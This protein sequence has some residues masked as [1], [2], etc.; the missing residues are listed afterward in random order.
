[1]NRFARS[2]I[3]G[4]A[5]TILTLLI[6]AASGCAA[7]PMSNADVRQNTA[8]GASGS[9]NAPLAVTG[10]E[11]SRPQLKLPPYKKTVLP[12]GMTL[13]LMEKHELP[14]LSG[15]FIVK[16]G[17]VAD[18]PGLE[19]TAALTSELLRRGTDTLTSRQYADSLDFIAAKFF[20]RTKHDYSQLY[21]GFMKKDL[22]RALQ[23]ISDPLMHPTFPEEEVAKA[24]TRH[25]DDVRS[26]KDQAGSALSH[27]YEAYLWGTHPYARPTAG[28]ELSLC[29][30]KREQIVDFYRTNYTPQNCILA[31]TG[32][33][34]T[35][36]MEKKLATL[37]AGW[38]G[39]PVGDKKQPVENVP[40]PENVQGKRL[41]L[42]DKPDSTQTYFELGNAGIS[43]TNPDRVAIEVVN[44]IF[45]ER[46]TSMLNTALR[47]KSGL[48]YGA[49]AWFDERKSE[50]PFFI[51]SFTPNATTEKAL[52]L[53]LAVL[54]QL[55]DKGIDREQLSSVRDYLK[56]QATRRLESIDQLSRKIAELE[57]YGLDRHDVDDFFAKVD[58][59]TV[60]DAQRIIKKYYPLDN[61]VFTVIGKS[62]EIEPV[63]RKY[64]DKRDSVSI[65]EKGYWPPAH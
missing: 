9:N 24:R 16:A 1:M 23:L 2:P 62:S 11:P 61:L 27:Y 5:A 15:M 21:F 31:I 39:A 17:S 54:K 32:D 10:A 48:T 41:L 44:T 22:D 56:G 33:F 4:I 18:P 34:S 64:A 63:L 46:F 26:A 30:I 53:A 50:G 12:N 57:F 7:D 60:A 25:I 58:A 43:A 6:A 3:T 14:V 8:P 51:T 19:G 59:V 35:E 38:H 29:R 40:S 42:I 36:E 49:G 20:E 13:L 55:H 45:G 47:I 65:S 52:D 37:F 28:D